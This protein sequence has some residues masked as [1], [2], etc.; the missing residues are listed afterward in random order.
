MG[1]K[2]LKRSI[3]PPP[4]KQG[5]QITV[6]KP[7]PEVAF[8]FRYLQ[9]GFDLD[10]L[11]ADDRKHVLSKMRLFGQ[12]TWALMQSRGK[13]TGCECLPKDAMKGKFPAEFADRDGFDVV[14]L[15]DIGRLLGFFDHPVF[16]VV[17]LDTKG[18]LYDHG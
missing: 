9:S 17:W 13:E 8:S 16:Y 4:I 1:N 14:R 11:E 15:P 5:E 2:H 7:V 10:I 12:Q 3:V 18:K 6:L